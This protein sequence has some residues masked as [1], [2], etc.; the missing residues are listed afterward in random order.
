MIEQKQEKFENHSEPT[1]I[2]RRVCVR[3][4][5]TLIGIVSLV[6]VA[7]IESTSLAAP[8]PTIYSPPATTNVS[9][10]PNVDSRQVLRPFHEKH[11]IEQ[12]DEVQVPYTDP[13]TGITSF[14]VEQRTRKVP[15]WTTRMVEVAVPKRRSKPGQSPIRWNQRGM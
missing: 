7:G 15:V 8:P 6:A 10:P 14:R 2:N 3:H 11:Y 5:S 12:S 13:T 1:R 9:E 4:V